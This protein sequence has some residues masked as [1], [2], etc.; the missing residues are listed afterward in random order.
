VEH[1]QQHQHQQRQPRWVRITWWVLG[2]VVVLLGAHGLVGFGGEWMHEALDE[3]VS[4]GAEWV[5][6]VVCF[7]G[8]ARA[9]RGR[10]AWFVIGVALA[11]WTI[12]DTIAAL[13]HDPE[14]LVSLSDIFWLA[15]YPLVVVALALLVRDRV[16][17][18][19][20]HRW[21]DGIVVMLVIATPWVALFLEPAAD[22]SHA[23]TL[24]AV[25]DFAYPLG[26]VVLVG[27]V[28]GVLAIM[29]WRA[30]PMWFA[31]AAAFTALGVA[32]AVYSVDAIGGR[33]RSETAFDALW[34]AGILL[35]A[36]AAWLPHPGELEPVEVTGWQAIAL[37]IAAQTLAVVIQVYGLFAYVPPGERVLTIVV[38]LISILQLIVTRPRPRATQALVPRTAAQ[39]DHFPSA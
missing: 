39:P 21:L 22:R 32:D 11:S 7:V 30:R 6:V 34:L 35:I 4:T 2:G 37:P 15:W 25:V 18:F 20:F 9:T 5:A 12:G 16:P 13:R 3:W 19:E 24:D 14:V 38:L 27:A 23:S 36:F 10:L 31:L 8:A 28:L 29:G 1:E 33:Y 26:D 17:V